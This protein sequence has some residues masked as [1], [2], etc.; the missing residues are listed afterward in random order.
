[1]LIYFL[2]DYNNFLDGIEIKKIVYS[3]YY[4]YSGYNFLKLKRF[5]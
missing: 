3:Q 2:F 4:D 5:R 1:M